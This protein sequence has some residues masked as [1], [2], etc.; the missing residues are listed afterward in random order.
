MTYTA[1]QL[2]TLTDIGARYFAH[3]ISNYNYQFDGNNYVSNKASWQTW[4]FPFYDVDYIGANTYT[5]TT[6]LNDNSIP[7]QIHYIGR[8]NAVTGDRT[9]DFFLYIM[10]QNGCTS[11]QKNKNLIQSISSH[12][13]AVF[14]T[15]EYHD[16]TINFDYILNA[17]GQV[18]EMHVSNPDGT[19]TFMI[20]KMTYY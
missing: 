8:T 5:Y 3:D 15:S 7:L 14:F 18:S 19:G 4:E 1:G 20:Y 9:E 11:L 6:L 12:Q 2:D 17:A 13:Q 10:E 16:Y